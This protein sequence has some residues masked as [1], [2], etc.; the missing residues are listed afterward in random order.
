MYAATSFRLPQR[1]AILHNK[2]P[3]YVKGHKIAIIYAITTKTRYALK[4]QTSDLKCFYKV[5]TMYLQLFE[6]SRTR[7]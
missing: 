4:K 6:G 7:I 1:N 3:N 5:N 2:L